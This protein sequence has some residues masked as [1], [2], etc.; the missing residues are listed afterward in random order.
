[1]RIK[2]FTIIMFIIL[3]NSLSYSSTNTRLTLVS[4]TPNSPSSGQGTIIIDVEASSD[5]GSPQI[6][7]FQDAFQIDATLQAQSPVVT[8]SN[9]LFPS[10]SYNTTEDYTSGVISYVYTFNSG[11][12][13]T[14]D[15]N[16]FTRVVRVSIQYMM[17]NSTSSISWYSDVPNF[18]VTDN[19]N[20]DITGSEESI[21]SGLLDFPLPVELSSF[22]ASVNL[23]SVSLNWKTATEI[24]NNGFE[25]ERK[26]GDQKSEVSSQWEKVGFV[27]GNGNS[28]SPKDYSFVDKNLT[29]GTKYIYRLKQI[30]NDGQYQYSKEIEVKVVPNQYT[31]YQNYPNPFNPTTTIKFNL[32]QAAE[33]NLTVY[34]ILGEKVMTLAN[35]MLEAGFHSVEFNASNLAS[36][37]YIY[38]LQASNF[39]E[40]KK[41][42]LI[43]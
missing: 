7:V 28:N 32:P 40:T 6:H 43:K 39:V 3:L 29:G 13:S 5:A 20:S 24:N 41:M 9:E 14:I 17:T 1:M 11:T 26:A 15:L 4:N 25:V 42:M 37:T 34:N 12:P 16:S 31:L 30:D 27:Q 10:D 35:G 38:R 22:S 23:N 8:F 18:F 33:V 36:G 21:S 19:S 2:F